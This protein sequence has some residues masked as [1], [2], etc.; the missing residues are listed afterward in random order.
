MRDQRRQRPGLAHQLGA[1]F[2][3]RR[4]ALGDIQVAL[5][6]LRQLQLSRHRRFAIDE[7]RI[8]LGGEALAREIGIGFA[9]AA[10]LDARVVEALAERRELRQLGALVRELLEER[11]ARVI[12]IVRVH[13]HHP[14]GV[15]EVGDDLVARARFVGELGLE[16]QHALVRRRDHGRRDPSGA[17]PVE[18]VGPEIPD[19]R[20]YD[21]GQH[22]E[23]RQLVDGDDRAIEARLAGC[24]QSPHPR[25]GAA[26]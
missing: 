20:Q 4:G 15:R 17:G 23:P 16:R 8:V 14:L 21:R 9:V 22:R 5:R 26:A 10:E 11:L 25:D 13:R 6:Q 1:T 2:A 19:E 12:E 24:H 3:Q 18:Q 7:A